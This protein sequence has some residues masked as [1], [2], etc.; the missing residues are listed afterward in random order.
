M[1]L[2][3]RYAVVFALA[4]LS[5]FA[6]DS[7]RDQTATFKADE[8]VYDLE[9]GTR[10]YHGNVR[11]RQGSIQLDCDRLVTYHNQSG[12][13]HK[14]VCSGE[15]GKFKQRPQGKNSD[16]RAQAFMITLD[17]R[18]LTLE[19]HARIE[20]A[21]NRTHGDLIVYDL[22]TEKIKV[23]DDTASSDT[24]TTLAT[25]STKERARLIIQPRKKTP[26]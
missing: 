16:A 26:K 9:N 7:D 13:V 5:A 1:K 17:K 23:G 6:L 20:H 22:H 2:K 8:I 14:S 3:I 10:T 4:S 18:V 21:G 25:K 15:P 24:Q 11:F 19:Q 12:E